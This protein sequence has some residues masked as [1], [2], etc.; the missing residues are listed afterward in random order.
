MKKMKKK[1]YQKQRA[2]YTMHTYMNLNLFILLGLL[3]NFVFY[4]IAIL[5]HKSGD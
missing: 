2:V 4:F 5:N 1:Q 3:L